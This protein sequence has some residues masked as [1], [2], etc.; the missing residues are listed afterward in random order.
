[1]VSCL[2]SLLMTPSHDKN[3]HVLVSKNWLKLPTITRMYVFPHRMVAIAMR[4]YHA[5]THRGYPAKRALSAMRKH[6]G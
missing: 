1:M 4:I 6:G 2:Y 3:K 5:I